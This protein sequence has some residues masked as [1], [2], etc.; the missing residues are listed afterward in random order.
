MPPKRRYDGLRNGQ[1][2]SVQGHDSS[3][4]STHRVPLPQRVSM[5]NPSSSLEDDIPEF[6]D[7][8]F[9]NEAGISE[10]SSSK[11][12]KTNPKWIVDV[13]GK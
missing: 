10:G 5:P 8:P 2:T 9:P 4:R 12:P 11:I 6:D 3:V 1:P 13:I 7:V